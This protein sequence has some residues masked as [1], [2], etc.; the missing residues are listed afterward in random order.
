MLCVFPFFPFVIFAP[1]SDSML[2]V[3]KGRLFVFDVWT[4]HDTH[5]MLPGESLLLG[6]VLWL[7]SVTVGTSR[8]SDSCNFGETLEESV[9]SGGPYKLHIVLVHSSANY[10]WYIGMF[11]PGSS[12]SGNSG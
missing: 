3:Q 1:V 11:D 4:M 7:L 5:G 12:Y 2:P 8:D 9:A 6:L 10:Q